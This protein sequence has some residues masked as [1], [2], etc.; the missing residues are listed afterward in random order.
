MLHGRRM[1]QYFYLRLHDS[2]G[3]DNRVS[4][5]EASKV[6]GDMHPSRVKGR[7]SS[8]IALRTF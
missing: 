2:P 5:R 1:Y 8:C 6:S 7:S 3:I 4:S